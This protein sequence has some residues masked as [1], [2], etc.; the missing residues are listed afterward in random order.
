MKRLLLE[1]SATVCLSAL[2]ENPSLRHFTA[3]LIVSR[4]LGRAWPCPKKGNA[5]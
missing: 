2:E 3:D 5:L 1:I 4:V